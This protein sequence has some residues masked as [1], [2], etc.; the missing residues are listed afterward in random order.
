METVIPKAN[1]KTLRA[2][3]YSTD[4]TGSMVAIVRTSLNVRIS[5]TL[6]AASRPTHARNWPPPP[7]IRRQTSCNQ[8]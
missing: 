8:W 6:A 2:C 7:S 4:V 3:E 1:V 5:H